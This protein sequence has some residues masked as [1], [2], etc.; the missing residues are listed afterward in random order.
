MPC[1]EYR[2]AGADDPNGAVLKTI[3]DVAETMESADCLRVNFLK[4][5]VF[6]HNG[7]TSVVILIG[8]VFVSYGAASL[9]LTALLD[10]ETSAGS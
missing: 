6:C 4:M 2:D 7:W 3:I 8:G 5:T 1:A 10:D 9:T